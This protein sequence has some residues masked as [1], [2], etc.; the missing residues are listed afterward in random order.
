MIFKRKPKLEVE[1]SA[2]FDFC[3]YTV[4]QPQPM[5]RSLP[6]W[7]K[8]FNIFLEG[9]NKFKY[10]GDEGG[11]L[12]MKACMPMFDSMTAGYTIP[13]PCD[14]QVT[15]DDAGAPEFKWQ[16]GDYDFISSH[17]EDQAPDQMIPDGFHRKPY[18]FMAAYRIKT[19]PGYSLLFT[20]PTNRY[21]LPFMSLTGIVD[22]DEY[23]VP[24]NFPFVLKKG[25]EGVIEAG[26]PMIQII[27]IKRQSWSHSVEKEVLEKEDW[28]RNI[29]ILST[30]MWKG[31]K[32]YFWNRKEYK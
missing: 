22:T 16:I 3:K 17:G 26:T 29:T 23:R 14:L 4:D 20:H 21:D 8:K 15:L 1:F 24:T 27:P 31:Y 12:T 10:I 19:P 7:W 28:R 30:R 5:L 18:K 6:D 11:N 13:F 9:E 25:F 2:D 32:R